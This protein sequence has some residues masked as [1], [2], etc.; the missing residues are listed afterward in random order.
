M[1]GVAGWLGCLIAGTPADVAGL[2]GESAALWATDTRVLRH[3]AGR[4]HSS[5]ATSASAAAAGGALLVLMFL[6]DSIGR[7]SV[8]RS[9]FTD[10]SVF[11]LFNQSRAVAPG[12]S[13]DLAHDDPPFRRRHR[14]DGRRRCGIC[15]PR[16]RVGT[17]PAAASSRDRRA[18]RLRQSAC[19]ASRCSAVCGSGG[20]ARSAGPLGWLS[21]RPLSSSW[22]TPPRP[23]LRRRPS[24]SAYLRGLSG[25]IHTVLLALI[26]LSFAQALLAILAITTVSRWSSDD[27]SGVLEMQLAE[28][29]PRWRVLLPSA[30]PS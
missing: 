9:P 23:S 13:F 10:I 4:R 17:D 25:D 18:R 19:S 27:S 14:G 12:G 24:L 3:R 1:A 28:P 6:L 29:L 20:S 21:P 7:S 15:S 30:P 11:F 22:S 2:V 16:R 8:N 26:W 5:S